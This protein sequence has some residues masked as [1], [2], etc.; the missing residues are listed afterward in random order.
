MVPVVSVMNVEYAPP[1]QTR[2]LA[3]A[4]LESPAVQLFAGGR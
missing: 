1:D 4:G 2:S 3:T